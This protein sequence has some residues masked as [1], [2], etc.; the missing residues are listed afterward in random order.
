VRPWGE[1]TF[2]QSKSMPCA[3]ESAIAPSAPR[4]I[5]RPFS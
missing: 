4:L 5:E 2:S 1:L 3:Q